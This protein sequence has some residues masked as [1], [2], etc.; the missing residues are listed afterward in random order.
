M[1]ISS[2]EILLN[3]CK[4]L[5]EQ[6]LAWGSS[7]TWTS[8]DFIELSE[9]ILEET[10]VNLSPTTLKRIWGKV[11]YHSDPNLNTMNTLVQFIGYESW[12]VFKIEH[13]KMVIDEG[14]EDE[15][16]ELVISNE[17]MIAAPVSPI[18]KHKKWWLGTIGALAVAFLIFLLF[19]KNLGGNRAIAEKDYLFKS[20]PLAK[21]LPNS[22]IF[23][24]D[25]ST[26]K[27]DSVFIQQSWD[28][29]RRFR[30]SKSLQEYTSIY[31][32]PG[33]FSAKLLVDG[34]IVKEHKLLI[35]S[36]GWFIAIEQEPVPVYFKKEEVIKDGMLH[37]PIS[38]IESK[39]IFL[40]P[41][42]PW[43]RYYNVQ[44]FKDLQNDNFI[45]ET[46][47]K[48]DYAQ[49]SAVCQESQILILC[50]NDAFSIPLSIKGCVANLNLFLAGNYTNGTNGN[51]SAFGVDMSN[52]VNVRCEVRNKKIKIFV[53]QQPAYEGTF[54][55]PPNKI[56]GINYRFQGTGSV[57]YTK[58]L[59]LNGELVFN[60][61]F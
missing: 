36:E 61:E 20:K 29:R 14:R 43:V 47:I 52:W 19:Q 12:K 21:G 31:Y 1:P 25:A 23:N 54:S 37:L 50:E 33:F 34:E 2:E 49:G 24:Y 22:V 55:N 4:N 53:N 7:E 45:F 56:I 39:N 32:Y 16:N 11:K 42:T 28:E 3:Q 57:N 17:N 35:P 9:K 5:I 27:T 59:R 41:Q 13:K 48:N 40:Q 26:A 46:E 10:K 51:L 38:L 44:E 60:D 18:P 15:A 58:F 6:K 30:V 8:Q